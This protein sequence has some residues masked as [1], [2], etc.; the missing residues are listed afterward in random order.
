MRTYDQLITELGEPQT[1]KPEVF[2]G[3]ERV[4]QSVCDLILSLSLV[5]ND[6]KDLIASQQLMQ[7]IAP[8][9]G[10]PSAARGMF[11]GLHVHWVRLLAGVIHELTELVAK[12]KAVIESDTFRTFLKKL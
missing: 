2:L 1:L 6:F 5:F 3:D 11:G 8:G 10:P 7:T 4:P 12:N 9:D